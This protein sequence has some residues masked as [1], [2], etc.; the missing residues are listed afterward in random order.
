MH[1]GSYHKSQPKEIYKLR[2]EER[3][4]KALEIKTIQKIFLRKKVHGLWI[5]RTANK[6][7]AQIKSNQELASF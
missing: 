3:K 6:N 5:H 4:I 2:I 7:A 1:S